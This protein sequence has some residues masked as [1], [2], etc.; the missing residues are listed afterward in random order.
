LQY[1][2]ACISSQQDGLETTLTGVLAW[3]QEL[4]DGKAAMV[5]VNDGRGTLHRGI[6]HDVGDIRTGNRV[7]LNLA[8]DAQATLSR[9]PE[10]GRGMGMG[11]GM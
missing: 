9:G 11:R 7:T 2:R 5:L 6:V 8:R 3:K 10:R 4:P 1:H